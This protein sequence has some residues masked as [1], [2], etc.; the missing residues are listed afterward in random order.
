MKFP[1]GESKK[2]AKFWAPNPSGPTF[3]GFGPPPLRAPHPF[4]PPLLQAPTKNKIGQMWSGQIRSTIIGQIRPNKDGQM[5]PVNFGQM[6]YWPNSVWPNAVTAERI[7]L[8]PSLA[9]LDRVDDAGIVVPQILRRSPIEE[10]NNGR[11]FSPPVTPKRPL[12]MTSRDVESNALLPSID[13]NV[14]SGFDSH[15]I[16][17]AWETHSHPARVDSGVLMGSGCFLNSPTQLLGHCA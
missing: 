15:N 12:N 3:S 11:T 2:S 7:P 5:Q 4:G 10:A 6:W 17:S 1:V 13:T 8:F 9:L 14:V 16:W